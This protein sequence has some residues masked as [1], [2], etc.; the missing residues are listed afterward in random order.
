MLAVSISLVDSFIEKA[1]V[2]ATGDAT[3]WVTFARERIDAIR[4]TAEAIEGV[5]LPARDGDV[6]LPPDARSDVS[7]EDATGDSLREAGAE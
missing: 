3:K 2:V 1:G 5:V 7:V 4:M 6:P